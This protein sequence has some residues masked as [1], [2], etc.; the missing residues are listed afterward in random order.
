MYCEF[1][2]IYRGKDSGRIV[3]FAD[4]DKD[5]VADAEY[6]IVSQPGLTHSLYVYKGIFVGMQ[7]RVLHTCIHSYTA[8]AYIINIYIVHADMNTYA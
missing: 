4:H 6:T 5:G 3:F 7:L 1:Y 8:Y 2:C